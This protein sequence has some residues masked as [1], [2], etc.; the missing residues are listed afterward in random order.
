MTYED[1]LEWIAGNFDIDDY[2]FFDDYVADIRAEFN[3]DG[4]IDALEFQLIEEFTSN[5]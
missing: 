4:L 5:K 3:N 2:E 1:A